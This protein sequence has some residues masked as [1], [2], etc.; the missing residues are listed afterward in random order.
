M[1]KLTKDQEERIKKFIELFSLNYLMT[2][3]VPFCNFIIDLKTK[4][5]EE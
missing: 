5:M 2:S 4:T 1:K 3:N